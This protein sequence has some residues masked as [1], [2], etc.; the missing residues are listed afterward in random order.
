VAR[1]TGQPYSRARLLDDPRY[2]VRLGT[3]YLDTMMSK[4]DEA[5]ALAL[6]AYNAGPAR[7]NRWIRQFGDPRT[8]DVDLVDWIEAIPFEETRNYV[9]RVLESETV[10]RQLMTID[11]LASVPGDSG[12]VSFDHIRTGRG[13]N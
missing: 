3:A 4:Y 7:V 9:Q 5:P 6:A 12:G 11:Q 2:N 1:A 8:G 10:Y 13:P